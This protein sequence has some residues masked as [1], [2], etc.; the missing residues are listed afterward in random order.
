[1]TML[2]H[3]FLN[4]HSVQHR[5]AIMFLL[6]VCCVITASGAN[7]HPL[8]NFSVN[9]YARL[10]IGAQRVVIRYVVDMAEIAA[11]QELN[12]I[13][14]TPDLKPTRD[15][16][17][18]YLDRVTQDYLN[19]LNL[20]VDE[21]RVQLKVLEKTISQPPGSGEMTTLRLEFDLAG[22]L[23][24]RAT[25]AVRHLQFKNN[26]H[27]D[28]TGWHEIVIS[29]LAGITVFDTS[30]FGS[31]L[32]EELRA[33][34]ENSLIAP[35]N[36]RHA[37][38]SFTAGNIPSSA[39]ALMTR[40]GQHASTARDRFPESNAFLALILTATLILL[41]VGSGMAYQMKREKIGA[42]T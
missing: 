13:T 35:L 37:D 31:G 19:G 26:N 12:K 3:S 38:L 20:I 42:R 16:L 17:K 14:T 1:M 11:F 36:E 39:K 18:S 24:R 30:S 34:P 21:E 9:Q 7:A 10:E 40:N 2:L 29:P 25:D 32:T 23:Q 6:A 5:L 4:R 33:Y 22:S 15:E 27:A 41:G 8:G 28:R